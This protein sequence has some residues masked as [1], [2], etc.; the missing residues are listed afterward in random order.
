[1]DKQLIT[2]SKLLPAK[3]EIID[4]SHNMKPM[5][6]FNNLK[7]TSSYKK[8]KI[9]IPEIQTPNRKITRR[10]SILDE[11]GFGQVLSTQSEVLRKLT[12]K[13]SIG[14]SDFWS[15]QEKEKFL[16]RQG[17]WLE[18]KATKQQEQLHGAKLRQSARHSSLPYILDLK[19]ERKMIYSDTNKSSKPK[20]VNFRVPKAFS[21]S[22]T[23]TKCLNNKKL[24]KIDALVKKCNILAHDTNKI[25]T[26]ARILENIFTN[27]PK[28][29]KTKKKIT[30][31]DKCKIQNSIN[32]LT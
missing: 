24:T 8:D 31:E 11:L 6:N 29:S 27:S 1:M 15:A 18:Y 7:L 12:R 4:S 19:T 23:P 3:N 28:S 5:I 25:R 14:V 9:K 21:S 13:P 32:S 17:V 16:K 26:S 20:I 30:K 2:Y 22:E 10:S